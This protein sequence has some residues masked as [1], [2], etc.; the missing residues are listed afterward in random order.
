MP[1]ASPP[2]QWIPGLDLLRCTAVFLVL[3]GHAKL[4]LPDASQVLFKQFFPMPAAWGV[5]LFFSLS[6]FLIGRRWVAMNLSSD[7]SAWKS[8]NQFVRNRWLRTMP[9]YWLLMALLLLIGAIS[10][11]P[12][13][14]LLVLLSNLTL[15][16]WITG[17]AYAL[18]VS[19][20][21]AIEEFSYLLI[22]GSVLIT[23][24]LLQSLEPQLRR[25]WLPLFPAL[26]IL[27]GILIR[28]AAV[29][30]GHWQD[31]SH[32]PW[33]RLD[34]L[35][36]GLLLACWVG[37]QQLTTASS[38]CWRQRWLPAL[39]VAGLLILQQW[40]INLLVDLKLTT[41]SDGMLFGMLLLPTI[42][43]ITSGW[44][45]LAAAWQSSGSKRLD[46][47]I[48]HLARISYSVYLVHIP[49]RTFM[50]R[51]W[52]AD[53]A[54]SGFLLFSSF[55]ALSILLGDLTYRLLEKPF[56]ILKQ[57]LDRSERLTSERATPPI[58]ATTTVAASKR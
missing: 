21:L 45:L 38:Q 44:V 39:L 27:I 26:L 18:P 2:K 24:P 31:L 34:S 1:E 11:G 7:G 13:A 4:L 10:L 5:E 14:G 30:T 25:Q 51:Q 58:A 52:T 28:I 23:L 12:R 22:G 53:T 17:T 41:P 9:T 47:A 15:T 8:V 6:G 32:S 50:L 54:F 20:T 36:Y 3:I 35:A 19:W 57:H 46:H 16:N 55:L 37:P 42:G 43:L 48:Q 33:H 49:L 40:R 29:Q 56:L